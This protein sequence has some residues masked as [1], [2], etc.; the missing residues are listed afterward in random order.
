MADAVGLLPY[1]NLLMS[2]DITVSSSET[3]KEKMKIFS[4]IICPTFC[5]QK[6]HETGVL[7]TTTDEVYLSSGDKF[8]VN[9]LQPVEVLAHENII[10]SPTYLEVLTEVRSMIVHAGLSD[11]YN[12]VTDKTWS[13]DDSGYKYDCPEY[14]APMYYSKLNY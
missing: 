7:L 13:C 1:D 14:W 6:L 4:A 9:T 8:T 3:K 5:N 10:N 11:Y 12:N 2:S